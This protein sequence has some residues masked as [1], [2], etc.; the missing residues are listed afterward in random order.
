MKKLDTEVKP[1]VHS[2]FIFFFVEKKSFSYKRFLVNFIFFRYLR[3]ASPLTVMNTHREMEQK[4]EEEDQDKI[5]RRRSVI[6]GFLL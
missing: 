1:C 6:K 4:E 3:I 2:F 5:V